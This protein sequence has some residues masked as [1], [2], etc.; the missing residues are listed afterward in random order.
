MRSKRG[1]GVVLMHRKILAAVTTAKYPMDTG[2]FVIE[3][4]DGTVM[5]VTNLR[6]AINV[7]LDDDVVV[8]GD[9]H[10]SL[11]GT[12]QSRPKGVFGAIKLFDTSHAA[13]KH[14]AAL[15]MFSGMLYILVVVANG[16][17][18]DVDGNVTMVSTR[19]Q[20]TVIRTSVSSKI[21]TH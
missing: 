11:F 10:F 1:C 19:L 15:G 18:C 16:A 3:D 20:K 2:I 12:S 9:I 21:S 14:V 4:D 17:A 7:T 5:H 8:T 13:A 6:S